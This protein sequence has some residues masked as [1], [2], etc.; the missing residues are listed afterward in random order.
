MMDKT[1]QQAIALRS[2]GKFEQSR[3]LLATLLEQDPLKARAHLHIAWSYDNQ[4]LESQAVQHYHAA[5]AGELEA[6][7]RF[8]ALFGL[9]STLR[10]LGQ[11]QE[12]AVWFEKTLALFPDCR[13]VKPFY[14]MCLY[15]LGK[16]KQAIELL[17]NLL[18]ETT[19]DEDILTYQRAIKLYAQDLDRTWS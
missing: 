4:G 12:T 3:Q 19:N 9:A 6:T 7:E 1:I 14:A 17:L 8:D 5:L 2:D 16:H 10:S 15:N 18:V 11:Y 13:E